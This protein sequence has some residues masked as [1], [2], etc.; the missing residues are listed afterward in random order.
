MTPGPPGLIL[1][2]GRIAEP[3]IE[4]GVARLAEAIGAVTPGS[5]S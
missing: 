2:Y 1:G 4:R 5:G 3:A